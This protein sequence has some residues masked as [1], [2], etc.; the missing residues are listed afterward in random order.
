MALQE[1]YPAQEARRLFIGFAERY[2][3]TCSAQERTDGDL[4]FQFPP[5]SGLLFT[6][7]VGLR[8]QLALGS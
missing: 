4:D 7:R 5:Q 3:L 1:V 2:A 8:H 6:I